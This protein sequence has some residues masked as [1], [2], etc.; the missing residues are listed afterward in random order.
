MKIV[1][2]Q[3]FRP[4]RATQ[5]KIGRPTK[6]EAAIRQ[7]E[8]L[9]VAVDLFLDLGF[10]D[11]TLELI[12][13]A[14]GMT[15][16]TIYS[17]HKDKAALF[18]ATVQRAIDRMIADQAQTL[19]SLE[20]E[21]LEK[22]LATVARMRIQQ[23]T[24]AIGIKLQRIVNAET[25]RFPELFQIASEQ[26]TKP[27][28]QFLMRIIEREVDAGNIVANDAEMAA[29][30]FLSMAVGAPARVAVSGNSA[31]GAGDDLRIGFL[32]DLFLHGL[33][34]QR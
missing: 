13:N 5:S 3:L 7:Q 18:I 1:A 11:A 15:K 29:S 10:D 27:V 26:I 20:G 19:D 24:S 8:L 17:R 23:V 34:S 6:A 16:R 14:A 31:D 9:D 28:V 21:P 33:R 30:A 22:V 32:I 4:V 25:R 2:T 12:A